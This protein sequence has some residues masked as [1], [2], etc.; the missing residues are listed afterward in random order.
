MSV[1]QSYASL[2]RA[3]QP[4]V[5][6]NQAQETQVE[7]SWYDGILGFLSSAWDIL[8]QILIIII[9]CVVIVK[10]LRFLFEVWYGKNLIRMRITLPRSDSKLDKERETKK[11]FKEKIGQMNMF[12]KAVHKLA[13]AGM[14][15]T[16]LNALFAHSKLSLELIYENGEVSFVI[17]TYSSFSDVVT[18]HITSIYNDAEIQIIPKN[19]YVKMQIL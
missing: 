8:L 4:Q 18:Q 17:S 11:D 10:I 2:G 1:G 12:Y 6:K 14:R 3:I 13:E 7:T 16:L 15:E 5:S 19:E 9:I